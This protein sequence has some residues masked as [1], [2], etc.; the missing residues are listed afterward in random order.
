LLAFE[1]SMGDYSIGAFLRSCWA[2]ARSKKIKI[3]RPKISKIIRKKTPK[4]N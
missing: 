1:A 3:I 4:T 2:S